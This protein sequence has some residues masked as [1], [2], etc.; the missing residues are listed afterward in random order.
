MQVDEDEIESFI[1]SGL[2]NIFEQENLI[3]QPLL[4]E[5]EAINDIGIQLFVRSVLLNSPSFWTMPV[6]PDDSTLVKEW[7][8]DV[9]GTNGDMLNTRRVFRSAMLLADSYQLEG[10]DRD[11][12]LA[13]TLVHSVTKY[14]YKNGD[15]VY[16]SFY[17]Y[18]F[19]SFVDELRSK[20]QISSSEDASTTLVIQDDLVRKIGRLVRC[21]NGP[22]SIIPETIPMNTL[23]ICMHIAFYMAMAVDYIIDGSEVIEE[24]WDF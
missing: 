10:E 8:K 11:L 9:Y 24:R 18:T 16:N 15:I 7:P 17:P 21:Q 2:S 14:E 23:E 12:L 1:S 20:Q 19:D 13:A 6:M 22:W 5:I 3:L 4:A